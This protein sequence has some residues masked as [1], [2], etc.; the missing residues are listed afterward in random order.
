MMMMKN[1]RKISP[2]R[3][4]LQMSYVL[5]VY[6]YIYIYVFFCILIYVIGYRIRIND[7]I[8]LITEFK[9]GDIDKQ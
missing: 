5:C 6:I 2:V 1:S 9:I 7:R 3:S 8:S 4:V